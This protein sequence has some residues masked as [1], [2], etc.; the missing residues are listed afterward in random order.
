MVGLFQDHYEFWAREIKEA[1]KGAGTDEK[2]LIPLILLQSDA[3]TPAVRAQYQK[4]YGKEMVVDVS[5]DI[6]NQDW[7]RLIKAWLAGQ[8]TGVVAPEHGADQLRAAAKG[9]GTDE[10]VFIRIMCTTRP[11][12][13]R[14]IAAAYAAKYKQS[15][16]E[17][18]KKEFTGK[19]EWAFLLA[20]YYL[21]NPAEAVAFVINS[22]VKG[23]GTNEEMLQNTTVL[24]CD[25]FKGQ[26]IKTGYAPFGDITKDLKRDLT[27][28]VEDAY[29]AVWGL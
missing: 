14:Q 1:I 2:K 29:L 23:L 10:D 18:I 11:D 19:S 21:M 7:A 17:L 24:F 8:N 9:A 13:Y 3:D 4:L 27:G 25:Y 28:K 22:A 6:G 16:A 26:T 20:H 12:C 15:L 5:N